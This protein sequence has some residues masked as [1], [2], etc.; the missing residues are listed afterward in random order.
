[1]DYCLEPEP[2]QQSNMDL[3]DAELVAVLA[4][5]RGTCVGK[6][7][8]PL[9]MKMTNQHP[10]VPNWKLPMSI[11]GDRDRWHTSYLI[12][13]SEDLSNWSSGGGWTV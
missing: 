13:G 11:T 9:Q 10:N 3:L 2:S 1:M 5:L 6:S 8:P 7:P 4:M 12:S